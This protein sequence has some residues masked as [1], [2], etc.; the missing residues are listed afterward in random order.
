MVRTQ[1][2]LTQQ[3]RADLSAL[4]EASGKTFSELVRDAVNR[5]IDESGPDRKAAVLKAASGLWRN[6]DD[7]PDFEAM[8]KTWSRS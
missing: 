6:R 4:A 2:Y 7:L 8:R 3:E 1:I 5:L